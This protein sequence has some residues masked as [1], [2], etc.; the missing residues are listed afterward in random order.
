M[1]IIEITEDNIESAYPLISQLRSHLSIEEYLNL[2]KEAIKEDN[3]KIF[4]LYKNE[5]LASVIGFEPMTTLYYGRFIWVCDLVTHNNFRSQ[6][7]G[8]I[9]LSHVEKIAKDKNYDAIALS[10]GL[11]REDAHRFYENKMN[12]S[13]PS[14]VF[15]KS[16][17]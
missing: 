17:N 10:S 16:F 1:N 8:E 2:V 14:Y 6:G 3:Y 4:G 5:E 12:Y 7:L 13:K 11:Q 15:K 9:L